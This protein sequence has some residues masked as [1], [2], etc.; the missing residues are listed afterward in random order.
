MSLK[1]A[2]S[3]LQRAP[4]FAGVDPMRLEVLAFTGTHLAFKSGD[5]FAVAGEPADGAFLILSGDAIAMDESGASR[6][7]R[8]I[9]AG[10][11]VGE[12]ALTEPVNWMVTVRAASPLEV[13]RL[14]REVFLRLA[15]EFP[16]IASGCLRSAAGHLEATGEALAHLTQTM[17]EQRARRE[18]A[19]R[20][21]GDETRHD[22]P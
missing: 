12:A 19:R 2:V 11:I 5:A 20:A 13:L 1:D 6:D 17:K 22:D 7:L 9:D 16:E 18:A 21:T 4:L 3:L 10:V 8:R 15:D 14:D